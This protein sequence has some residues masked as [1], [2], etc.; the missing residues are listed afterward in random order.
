MAEQ[1]IKGVARAFKVE[2]KD[3]IKQKILDIAEAGDENG[4]PIDDFGCT[5][6]LI[7]GS[8]G[9]SE[10]LPPKGAEHYAEYKANK[11]ATAK[12][13]SVAQHCL[14]NARCAVLTITVDSLL[15]GAI[16]THSFKDF[17]GDD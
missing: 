14:E 10:K 3:L 13:G 11:R 4:D 12:K 16:A 8:N 17:F 7:M 9:L 15:S 6:I 1:K 5:D 2:A